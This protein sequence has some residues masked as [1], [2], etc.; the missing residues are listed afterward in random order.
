[1]Q[2][3][4]L[5]SLSLKVNIKQGHSPQC[6]S[7]VG[8]RAFDRF[9]VKVTSNVNSGQFIEAIMEGKASAATLF[10]LDSLQKM[11]SYSVMI[12]IS[13]QCLFN[14]ELRFIYH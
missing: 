7:K 4:R 8:N 6:I 2:R 1:M 14:W 9:I 12:A 3:I 13:M 10:I 11:N 5:L